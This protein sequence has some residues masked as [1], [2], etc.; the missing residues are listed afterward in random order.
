MAVRKDEVQLDIRF[1]TDESRAL[2]RT[3]VDTKK[4]NDE[5]KAAQKNINDYR[6]ELEKA[7]ADETKRAVALGKIAEA[8]KKVAAGYNEIAAAG[9]KVEG[10][11]LSKVTPAQLVERARQLAI[12][13]RNIP[14][15]APRFK[16]LQ[17]ELAKVN[18]QLKITN[19]TAKGIA[20]DAGEGGL[21]GKILGVAGGVGLF[22][23]A[24][25][26]I[27]SLV[28]FGKTAV[29]EVDSQ[30]KADA[31][32]KEAI[33][34]TAGVA[35][36]SLSELKGQA[37]ALQD[38]TLFSDD[39]TQE[40]QALLLTFTNIGGE[41]FDNTIPII[42]DLAT[43]FKQDLSSSSIQVGKAL[44]DPINGV[45]AL[46]RVGIT[47][48]GEQK[49]LI[50]TLVDTGDVAGAQTII[51]KELERQVG[52]SAQAAAKAGAG[53]FQLL[54]NQF[55]EIKESI[56][57]LILNGL[58]KFM[59]TIQ[60]ITS[61][62]KDFVSVPLSEELRSQQSEF[63]A[64]VGV[65]QDTN[66]KESERA[67]IIK[68][69]KEQYPQYLQF[70]GDDAQGQID[71]AKTLE[72]G[73]SLFEKRILL[74]ATEEERTALTKE[75]IRLENE[76]TKALLEQQKA[77]GVAVSRGA[78]RNDASD[79]AQT[80]N[81]ATQ[82]QSRVQAIRTELDDI[83]SEL[84]DLTKTSDETALRTTGK[85]ISQL[86]AEIN[87]LFGGSKKG[88]GDTS[89]GGGSGGGGIK[90]EAEAAAGSLAF[91]RKQIAELQKQIEES[92]NDS[93]V[94][95]PLIQQLKIAERQLQ[96][97]EDK[98][99]EL[100]NPTVDGP[101]SLG[102][103]DAAFGTTTTGS[104]PGVK[105]SELESIIGF[106]DARVEDELITIGEIEAI[107]ADAERRRGER[108]EAILSAAASVS[109]AY[110]QIRQ[111]QL[112]QETQSTLSAL[113]AQYAGRIKAAEGN[114]REQERLQRELEV[115][116]AKIEREA[117][118]KR[119]ALAIQEAVIA[120]ALA[121]VKALPNA[122]AAIAA[123]VAAAA[124]IAI[125]S[126]QKFDRGG[127]TGRGY[128]SRDSSGYRQAG[129]VH[130]GEYVAPKWQV[131]HPET[132]PVVRWLENRRLRGYASGGLVTL[133]TTPSSIPGP[134]SSSAPSFGELNRLNE[135]LGMLTLAVA[136]FP[137]TVKASVGILDIEDKQG[138][139][140]RVR[141]S[142]SI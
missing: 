97:L 109:D 79:I 138:E 90:K 22:E 34:S 122:V 51:L 29:A 84:I 11:D 121:V 117:A 98:I 139:L 134:S 37:E 21:F 71:L 82:T 94:L 26:A 118:K 42:Q 130:E 50:K 81:V 69:L 46:Q 33:R 104:K 133:N 67:G 95:K 101:P 4:Y 40:A 23:L 66:T 124:Q 73:N 52:G 135:T 10:I 57:G 59:S 100:N 27:N 25:G 30:L 58:T 102:D 61:A 13:M 55:G 107:D 35:G 140:D 110:F 72:F 141:D 8:E 49:K 68:T 31:Q 87:G 123:G 93:K 112:Q 74:Q 47:F 18:A 60:A 24:K 36:K 1:V 96:A 105:D 48:S 28:N 129:I 62:I 116:K 142:A 3:L 106:N 99:K 6:K 126:S 127:Y 7:G 39:Q 86:E 114:S 89:G 17:A 125:I 32:I 103:I 56:G 44:N 54:K 16:E 113:D 19:D 85:S 75:K 137:R 119:K 53:P 9:K 5:I 64:L 136:N 132:A 128:G 92:P 38:V 70:V 15:S 2:A 45:T 43:A 108:R 12:E 115:K 80:E 111:N 131:D 120:G 65:L 83:R 91:L 20:A 78:I 88:S 14:Q 63:N 41:I 76:L 77:K